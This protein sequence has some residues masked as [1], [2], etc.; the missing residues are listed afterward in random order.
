MKH[1]CNPDDKSI[2][3]NC[4]ASADF[5]NLRM[6]ELFEIAWGHADL[7]EARSLSLRMGEM[8]WGARRRDKPG[9]SLWC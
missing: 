7:H 1:A 4:I 9:P 3:V 2:A 5:F 8:A 6:H